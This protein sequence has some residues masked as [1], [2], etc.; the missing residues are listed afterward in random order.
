MNCDETFKDINGITGFFIYNL[1][2][3][4][5]WSSNLSSYKAE[6]KGHGTPYKC[7]NALE[8]P[9]TDMSKKD[10]SALIVCFESFS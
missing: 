9:D 5:N 4:K 7:C 6:S 2:W 8:P 3:A 1:F 10:A